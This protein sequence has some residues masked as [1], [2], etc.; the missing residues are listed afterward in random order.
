MGWLGLSKQQNCCL[1]VKAG[2]SL[3][4]GDRKWCHC[5]LLP[6][7]WPFPHQLPW[8]RGVPLRSGTAPGRPQTGAAGGHGGHGQQL[9]HDIRLWVR[10]ASASWAFFS[11]FF[12][13][14][15]MDFLF[16]FFFFILKCWGCLSGAAVVMAGSGGFIEPAASLILF[17][18]PLYS[19]VMC[20][21]VAAD[22][23]Q[24]QHQLCGVDR[25]VSD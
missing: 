13:Q 17:Q 11:F 6:H 5:V 3:G 9:L 24:Y 10:H 7:R 2:F 4:P 18:P 21:S 25:C 23:G 16:L 22:L 20:C 15:R 19:D 12:L 8:V 14:P 1:M